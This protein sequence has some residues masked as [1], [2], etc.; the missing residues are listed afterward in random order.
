MVSRDRWWLSE[1]ESGG[2]P[3]KSSKWGS[4]DQIQA[5]IGPTEILCVYIKARSLMFLWD[6]QQ[7]KLEHLWLFCLHLVLYFS[8]WVACPKSIGGFLLALLLPS[9]VFLDAISWSTAMFWR[10]TENRE[11]GSRSWKKRS[12][13]NQ[14]GLQARETVVR[15]IIWRKNTISIKNKMMHVTK[16]PTKVRNSQMFYSRMEQ[17][18]HLKTI[19]LFPSLVSFNTIICKVY[20]RHP[21]V[22]SRINIQNLLKS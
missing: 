2:W 10:E 19:I 17:T 20:F 4:L 14:G 5:S 16:Y 11:T 22:Y 21:H 18:P 1:T 9:F 6:P 15:M 12:G 3:T 8:N 13:G 7:E